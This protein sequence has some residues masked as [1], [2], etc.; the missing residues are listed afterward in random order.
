MFDW[1]GALRILKGTSGVLSVEL[2]VAPTGTTTV[3]VTKGDGSLLVDAQSAT[4]SGTTL[5]YTLTPA[6]TAEVENL[7]ATWTATV[8]GVQQTFVTRAKVV[9]E[10]LFTL[11]E[12][13]AY[14]DGVLETATQYP[15][16]AVLA[17]REGASD[18]LEEALGRL[19]GAQYQR[20][21]FDGDGSAELD[22]PGV[23]VRS[24]R[25]VKVREFGSQTWTAFT[26]S[27]LADVLV[28]ESGLLVR[29]SLGVWP[30]GRRN[31]AVEW[32]AGMRIPGELKQAGLMLA[33]ELLVK[34]DLSNRAVQQVN[35][36]GTVQLA[37]AGR[38]GSRYGV[39]FIDAAVQ[40]YARRVPGVA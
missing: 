31:V 6:E 9:G 34:S 4:V 40:A 8:G 26:V 23:D 7:T 30:R 33:R 12:A 25:S 10:L 29:E 39:P 16:V 15:D 22:L 11:A 17:A 14:D 13:R 5:T 37:V 21:V 27:E 24:V 3:T 2:G 20:E 32:E 18:S 35:E 36:L 28:E 38:G 19:L 1:A